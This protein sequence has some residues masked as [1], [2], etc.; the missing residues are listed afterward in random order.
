ADESDGALDPENAE[1]FTALYR[2]FM[3]EANLEQLLFISHKP[4]CR[5]MADH[6]LTF[7]HGVNPS[8]G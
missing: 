3:K 6:V 1:K 8:W 4:S 2:P 7:A 5:A